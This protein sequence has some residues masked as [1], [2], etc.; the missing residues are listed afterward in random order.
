MEITSTERRAVIDT[1]TFVE[2]D[3]YTYELL[4]RTFINFA[5]QLFYTN[6][7]LPGTVGFSLPVQQAVTSLYSQADTTAR[8]AI[9]AY[10]DRAGLGVQGNLFDQPSDQPVASAS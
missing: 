8:E 1:T 9:L 4:A 5:D 2:V 7:K 3:G 10:R 6:I